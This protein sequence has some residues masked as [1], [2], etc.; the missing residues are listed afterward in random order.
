MARQGKI[1]GGMPWNS[2]RLYSHGLFFFLPCWQ[3]LTFIAIPRSPI[4]LAYSKRQKTM[5]VPTFSVSSVRHKEQ[6][7]LWHQT[8]WLTKG[9]TIPW[10]AVQFSCIF[11]SNMP[12][13][14][15][16]NETAIISFHYTET[17]LLPTT[18]FQNFTEE[19][20]F[21]ICISDSFPPQGLS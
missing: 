3:R 5:A 16:R 1:R 12:Y 11:Q 13:P 15:F 9:K 19:V 18:H 20:S 17:K 10:F 8:S 4:F 2:S 7:F 21:S 6:S 14:S